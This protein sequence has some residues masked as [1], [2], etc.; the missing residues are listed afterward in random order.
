[1][2]KARLRQPGKPKT[3]RSLGLV[4]AVIY[5]PGIKP[6]HISIL[7]KE[8]TELFERVTRS[9]MVEVGVEGDTSFKVFIKEIQVD[10]VTGKFLHVDLYVPEPNRLLVM[11]VPIKLVGMA[12]G[13]KEGG[14][15]EQV[16]NYIEVEA[17]PSKIPSHIEVDISNLALGDSILVKDLHW[18][19][20]VRPLLRPDDV[21]VSML[22]PVILEAE[23]TE[24]PE[25]ETTV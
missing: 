7:E 4:P 17:I 25:G 22:A 8:L 2:I 19:E 21:V 24:A 5:G 10:P 3:D 20:G 11:P 9:T 23:A 15:L 18:E 16:H 14:I 1:M 12:P 13:V 6:I